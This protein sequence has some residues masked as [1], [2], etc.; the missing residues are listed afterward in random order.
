VQSAFQQRRKRLSNAWRGLPVDVEAV[1][2]AAARADIDLGERG[3]TL[4]VTAFAR[5]ARE[6]EGAG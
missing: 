3:E 5:M 2:S 6:L 4:D 1:T